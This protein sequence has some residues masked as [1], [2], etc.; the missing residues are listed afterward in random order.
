MI[1]P[2]RT[3]IRKTLAFG[4]GICKWRSLFLQTT[5]VKY[6]EE[7]QSAIWK[8]D[9]AV[10][11]IVHIHRAVSFSAVVMCLKMCGLVN[12]SVEQKKMNGS[13]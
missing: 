10:F 3:V 7:M 6:G 1:S 11:V 13:F 8:P 4:I 12:G 2:T 9:A 5:L